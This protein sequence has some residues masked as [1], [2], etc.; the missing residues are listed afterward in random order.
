MKL[1]EHCLLVA[2]I[3]LKFLDSTNQSNAKLEFYTRTQLTPLDHIL[4]PAPDTYIGIVGKETTSRY[5]LEI[6]DEHVP[7]F[8]IQYRIKQY[9]E[10][11]EEQAWQNTTDKP[12]PS[13]L[14]VCADQVKMQYIAALI[15][16][17][18]EIREQ[19]LTVLLTTRKLVQLSDESINSIWQKIT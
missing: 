1:R 11:Y 12:F 2:D 14:I 13:I 18:L 10:Y 15:K 7:R 9:F 5:F 4:K 19:Q 8:A 17:Q 6:I 3:Y 16:E